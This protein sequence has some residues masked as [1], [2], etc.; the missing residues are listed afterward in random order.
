MRSSRY[1]IFALA[2]TVTWHGTSKRTLV[3]PPPA[4]PTDQRGRWNAGVAIKLFRTLTR[5]RRT[6]T[7]IHAVRLLR[8]TAWI[9]P[10][11]CQEFAEKAPKSIKVHAK[12]VQRLPENALQSLKIDRESGQELPKRGQELPSS[13]QEEHKSVFF[14]FFSRILVALRFFGRVGVPKRDPRAAQ[15]GEVADQEGPRGGPGSLPRQPRGTSEVNFA[16]RNS[17]T[18]FFEGALWRVSLES[19]VRSDFPMIFE[20]C[21]QTLNLDFE[22]TLW[23]FLRFFAG[24]VFFERVGAIKR[25]SMEKSAKSMAGDA[26]FGSKSDQKPAKIA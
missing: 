4:R 10:G 8:I 24:R 1:A 22:A 19:R 20:A 17:K 26:R 3:L 9:V 21:A 25:K 12:R 15:E 18:S 7:G 14:A 13:A 23:C 5:D 2:T 11:L 16:H 6:L